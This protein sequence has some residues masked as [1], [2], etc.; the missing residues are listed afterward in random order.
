MPDPDAFTQIC[1]L[2]KINLSRQETRQIQAKRASMQGQSQFSNFV[3]A[4]GV[5]VSRIPLTSARLSYT[6]VLPVA[7]FRHKVKDQ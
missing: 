4:R 5:S 3:A 1:A 6:G 7:S 2:C